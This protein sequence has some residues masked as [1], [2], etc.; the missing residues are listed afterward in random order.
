MKDELSKLVG[1]YRKIG[2]V[3]DTNILLLWVV[4]TT[5]TSRITRFK[6]TEQFSEEDFDLLV[7]VLNY[8]H[9]IWTTPNILTEVYNFANQ[10]RGNEREQALSVFAA[11][12]QATLYEQYYTSP[13]LS[14]RADFLRLGLTDCSIIE[15]AEQETVLVLTDDFTLANYLWSYGLDAINFNHL[16]L[17]LP[18]L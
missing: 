3:V 10:L 5:N 2:V 12:I 13:D 11:G 16:R 6:R 8:F 4:G 15:M 1:R 14:L 17:Y 18:K 7:D 9:Q